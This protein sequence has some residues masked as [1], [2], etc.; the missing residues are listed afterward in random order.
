MSFKDVKKAKEK[1]DERCREADDPAKAQK[2]VMELFAE[3][4]GVKK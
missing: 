3:A 2:L 4:V 1:L